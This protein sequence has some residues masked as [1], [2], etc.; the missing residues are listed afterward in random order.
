MIHTT[1]DTTAAFYAVEIADYILRI[2]D[3][4]NEIASI[5]LR[6]QT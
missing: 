6:M 3:A 1:K 4:K 2:S 5:A